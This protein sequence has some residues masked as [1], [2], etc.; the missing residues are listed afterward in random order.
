MNFRYRKAIALGAMISVVSQFIPCAIAIPA[1]SQEQQYIGNFKGRKVY[2]LPQSIKPRGN[3]KRFQTRDIYTSEQTDLLDGYK[4]VQ[5]INYWI[6]NCTE[7]SIGFQ[8]SINFD[9]QGNQIGEFVTAQ[10]K[11]KIPAPNE[12]REQIIDSACD[13][14]K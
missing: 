5:S 9:R 14:R 7:G 11:F 1:K 12:M 4:Y 2:L 3:L 6:A 10:L 8:K 13:Y